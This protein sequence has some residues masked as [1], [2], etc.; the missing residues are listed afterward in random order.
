LLASF[1]TFKKENFSIQKELFFPILLYVL[2][3]VSYFW[4]I[5]SKE[6]LSALSKDW[7]LIF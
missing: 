1:F 6:T 2:M 3:A 4:S 5:D 7:I